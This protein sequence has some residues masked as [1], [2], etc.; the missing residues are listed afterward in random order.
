MICLIGACLSSTI[1]SLRLGL[2]AKRNG[3]VDRL[4]GDNWSMRV[5]L[6]LISIASCSSRNETPSLDEIVA[7]V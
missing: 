3:L 6:L 4:L 5:I 7:S 2:R 1:L